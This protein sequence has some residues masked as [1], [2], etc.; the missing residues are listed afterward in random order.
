MYGC[1]LWDICQATC[2]KFYFSWRKNLRR[3]LNVP[4]TTHCNLLPL[5]CDDLNIDIQ[6][7]PNN[8]I[9][10][11]ASIICDLCF[12]YVVNMNMIS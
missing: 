10:I 12:F 11:I 5:I 1:P 8:D 7:Y 2:H 6:L 4:N 9:A 3:L